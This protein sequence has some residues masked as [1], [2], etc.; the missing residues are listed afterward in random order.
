MSNHLVGVAEICDILGVSRQRVAQII[1][2][3]DDFP[4][5]EVEIAAGRV[6]SR[7]VVQTWATVHHHRP[8]GKRVAPGPDLSRFT[9]RALRSLEEASAAARELGHNFIGTE[10]LLLAL[11]RVEDGIA[12]KVLAEADV[13]TEAI[14]E[15][16]LDLIGRGTSPPVDQPPFTPRAMNALI[17]S[18]SQALALGHNYVGTEHILLALFSDAEG[19][20]SRVLAAVGVSRETVQQRVLALLS[21]FRVM[22]ESEKRDA[23]RDKVEDLAR[24]I[25]ALKSQITP[26]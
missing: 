17:G 16:I 24:Q 13:T 26:P 2:T 1:E 15:K 23:L 22:S 7:A 8:P 25:D 9:A 12:A 20:A 6:W 14:T 4:E 21:G 5:P 10:H 11:R 3:Y 18:V 19:V